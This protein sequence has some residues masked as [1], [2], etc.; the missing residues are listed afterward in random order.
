MKQTRRKE[1]KSN[2]LKIYLQQVYEA[3]VRNATYLIGGAVV[4]VLVLV[5][6]LYYRHSRHEVQAAGWRAYHEIAQSSPG[7]KGEVI[8]RARNLAVEYAGDPV[9]GPMARQLQADLM[10]RRALTL[11][12][13]V[14]RTERLQLLSDAR[15]IYQKL[16][17]TE[18]AN[19]DTANR[20]RMSLAAVAESLY[21]EGKADLTLAEEQYRK[22]IEGPPNAYTSI[23]RSRLETL[24]ERAK[25]LEIVATRPADTTTA[26]ATSTAPGDPVE[27]M[28]ATSTAPVS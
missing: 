21:V 22:L 13:Q 23:A 8:D 10:Y 15:D 5:I 7:E 9:L 25:R 6:G 14:N 24:P 4:V 11:D 26:P 28:P 20:A 19:S 16:I 2:E 17:D 27:T 18:P 1:L 3:A 12:T